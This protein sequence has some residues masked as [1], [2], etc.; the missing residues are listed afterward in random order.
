M[1]MD[2]SALPDLPLPP[3]VPDDWAAS[4]D[5]QAQ[6]AALTVQLQVQLQ[7]QL[8]ALVEALQAA[9]AYFAGLAPT[10]PPEGGPVDPVPV[11]P[12]TVDLP[13]FYGVPVE[14]M[15]IDPISVPIDPAVLL[16]PGP[17]VLAKPTEVDRGP[18]GPLPHERLVGAA[19][20]AVTFGL[21]EG[22]LVDDLLAAL[23]QAPCA[24][25]I[26]LVRAFA[27]LSAAVVARPPAAQAMPGSDADS[28]LRHGH[29]GEGGTF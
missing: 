10:K 17:P 27:P 4:P 6:I 18:A 29:G 8:A 16:P 23:P 7:A 24:D 25:P 12:V 19:L 2:P 1:P 28:L 9:A 26:H 5:I 3:P 21:P 11:D 13:P 20:E 14:L 15:P 22:S